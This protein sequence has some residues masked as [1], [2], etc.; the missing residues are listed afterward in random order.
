[1]IGAVTKEKKKKDF[2]RKKGRKR[3]RKTRKGMTKS[4]PIS[5]AIGPG[6]LRTPLPL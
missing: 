1:V 5:P 4:H 3:K 2:Q 6:L